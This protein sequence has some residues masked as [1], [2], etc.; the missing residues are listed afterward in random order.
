MS[1]NDQEEEI[2]TV[3]TDGDDVITRYAGVEQDRFD[4]Y[5]PG[6]MSVSD[7]LVYVIN[8]LLTSELNN[9]AFT[10]EETAAVRVQVIRQ[11]LEDARR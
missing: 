11:L 7:Y 2:F 6:K 5:N 3:S 10:D 1:L 8:S 4:M 9:S